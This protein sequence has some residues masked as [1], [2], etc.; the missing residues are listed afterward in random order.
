MEGFDCEVARGRRGVER[1]EPA[2]QGEPRQRGTQRA[3]NLGSERYKTRLVCTCIYFP[4]CLFL[5]RTHNIS[6]AMQKEKLGRPVGDFESWDSM[7]MKKPD[8]SQPQ[9]QLPEYFSI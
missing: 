8:L 1:L 9:P 5:L 2:E 4:S 7:R 3:G 6:L